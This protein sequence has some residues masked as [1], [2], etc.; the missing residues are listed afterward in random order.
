MIENILWKIAHITKLPF[1]YYY[2]GYVNALWQYQESN[3]KQKQDNKYVG[4]C[5]KR[6]NNCLTNYTWSILT[7]DRISF[8]VSKLF[9]N[10]YVSWY[11]GQTGQ[12]QFS[13]AHRIQIRH[14]DTHLTKWCHEAMGWFGSRVYGSLILIHVPSIFSMVTI[15]ESMQN[16]IDI[17]ICILYV[18]CMY[19]MY[20]GI[21]YP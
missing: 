11:R 10:A 16:D 18:F 6:K 1:F 17:Y 3:K 8:V 9:P 5:Q 2:I 15:S 4:P 21:V 20:Y 12:L 14:F 13:I 19:V 7:S